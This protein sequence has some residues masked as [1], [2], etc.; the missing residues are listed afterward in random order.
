MQAKHWI[1]MPY[2][3][4]L[5]RPNKIHQK[6]GKHELDHAFLQHLWWV[7]LIQWST[8]MTN[9]SHV[10]KFVNA[11]HHECLIIPHDIALAVSILPVY[12]MT[13]CSCFSDFDH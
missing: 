8:L 13:K 4:I 10:T 3:R 9:E 1:K 6:I 12:G 2:A 11:T 7:V 5:L